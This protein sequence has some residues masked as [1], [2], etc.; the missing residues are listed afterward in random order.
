MLLNSLGLSFQNVP[1]LKSNTITRYTVTYVYTGVSEQHPP[2]CSRLQRVPSQQ[3]GKDKQT[4]QS[5][6]ESS[7]HGREGTEK[8][9]R[10]AGERENKETHG[11]GV[12]LS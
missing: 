5:S 4:E 7:R 12:T 11:E 2:A 10:D 3:P 1:T 8:E 9:T 6:A